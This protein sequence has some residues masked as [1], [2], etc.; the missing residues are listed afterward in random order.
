MELN[1]HLPGWYHL[2][3]WHHQYRKGEYEAA[4][5]TAKKI[6]MPE[7]HW[8]QLVTA[9]ACGMVGRREEAHTAI[10]LLRKYNATFLDLDNVREDIEKWTADKDVVEQLLQGLQKAGLKFGTAGSATREAVLDPKSEGSRVPAAASDSDSGQE[11]RRDSGAVR[12]A[13]GLCVAVLPFENTSGDPDSEYLSDGI[14]ETLINSLTQLGRLRVPARS[15]VFRYK[16]RTQDP[17]QVGR[18]LGAMAVLTGRVLQRGQTLV[19]GAELVDV[20]NGLQ[21]WG[22]RYKRNAA[23]IFDVQEEIAKVIFDKLRITLTPT[24][25]KQ[26]A[27]RYTVNPEAYEL[28]LKGLF[29]WNKWSPEGF[30]KAQEFFRQAIV[31]DPT[32]VPA[33]EGLGHCFGA[34]AYVGL[35][36]PRDGIAKAFEVGQKALALDEKI[37]SGHIILGLTEMTYEWNLAAGE[38]HF[39][40]AVELDPN[41]ALARHLHGLALCAVGRTVEGISEAVKAAQAEPASPL[42]VEGIGLTQL[43]ARNYKEAE[44]ALLNALELD[45][46]FLLARLDLGEV[47]ALTGRFEEAIQEF[48]RAVDDSQDNPYAV[49]YF[50]YACGLA[51]RRTEADSALLKLKELA[52]H[53]YVPPLANALV[54]LGRGQM[55][56]VFKWLDRAYEERDCR[57][58]PFL[59]IDPI[60]DPLRSDPRFEELLRRVGLPPRVAEAGRGHSS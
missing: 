14:T 8:A 2:A 17:Q 54:C 36:S 58:F 18:E 11:L 50:G 7:F 35:V 5:Q 4:L 31:K 26:L 13:Q 56:E 19:I 15:T 34:R 9:A 47:Y 49:G 25:E 21:L 33:Y 46:K 20:T 29:F 24:E 27:K 43:W 23:D 53:T 55:D 32:Y 51:G 59:H 41:S 40:R 22:E 44:P 16:G 52:Q 3:V 10:E 12:A 28:Y 39:K 60:F 57:R 38:R 48:G 1:R 6:N 30:R 37:P 42:I 45:P